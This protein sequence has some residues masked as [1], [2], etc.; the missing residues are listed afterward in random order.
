MSYRL[1]QRRAVVRPH[2]IEGGPASFRWEPRGSATYPR[3]RDA[4]LAFCREA[5][6]DLRDRPDEF[7]LRDHWPALSKSLRVR[8]ARV[9]APL[10]RD[11]ERLI[12]EAL[13]AHGCLVIRRQ[14]VGKPGRRPTGEIGEPDLEV[15]VGA[16]RV[17]FL[18][19]KRPGGRWRP[20]QEEALEERRRFGHVAERVETLE[21]ALAAL[22]QAR[23]GRA[24]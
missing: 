21:E 19:V 6:P 12:V 3:A 15:H 17:L 9:D 20:G 2:A 8:V 5:E 10:E 13:R 22:Q 4:R 16:G 24:A 18:E 23:A 11:V 7:V 1:E 14:H